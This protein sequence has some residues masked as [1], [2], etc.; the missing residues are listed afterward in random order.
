MQEVKSRSEGQQLQKK[1]KE[2]WNCSPSICPVPVVEL[3][4][5][6]IRD[7]QIYEYGCLLLYKVKAISLNTCKITPVVVFNKHPYIAPAFQTESTSE[8]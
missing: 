4:Q 7:G 5:C 8:R 2:C 3:I 6:L 1:K